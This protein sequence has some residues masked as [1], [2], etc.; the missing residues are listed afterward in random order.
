M[1]RRGVKSDSEFFLTLNFWGPNSN[2]SV[3]LE[4]YKRTYWSD[5][6]TMEDIIFWI[7]WIYIRFVS[8]LRQTM[9]A[10]DFEL[11]LAICGT[12]AGLI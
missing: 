4:T 2:N 1:I 12:K 3:T 9:L 8:R 11:Q 7:W 10:S 6:M 5:T